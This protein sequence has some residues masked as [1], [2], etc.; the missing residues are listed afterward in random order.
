MLHK[1]AS[2]LFIMTFLVLGSSPLLADGDS[3]ESIVAPARCP[4]GCELKSTTF[5]DGSVDEFCLNSQ[6]GEKEGLYQRFSNDQK[7]KEGTYHNGKLEGLWSDY[8]QN[9]QIKST[10]EMLD[11][12]RQGIWHFYDDTGKMLSSENYVNGQLEG[13]LTHY[14]KN[15]QIKDKVVYVEGRKAGTF[16]SW[17]KNGKMQSSGEILHDEKQGKWEHWQEDGSSSGYY[18]Y[19]NNQLNG[20]SY[21]FWPDGKEKLK[22]NYLNG[23]YDGEFIEWFANGQ[24]KAEGNYTKGKKTGKWSYW[25]EDGKLQNSRAMQKEIYPLV[26]KKKYKQANFLI[27]QC[28]EKFP[29]DRKCLSFKKKISKK[30]KKTTTHHI[31]DAGVYE[32]GDGYQTWFTLVNK[33]GKAVKGVGQ[34]TFYLELEKDKDL[35]ESHKLETVEVKA[36]E[37]E[38][39]LVGEYGKQRKLLSFK[40]FIRFEKEFQ[41]YRKLKYNEELYLRFEFV[42][43]LGQTHGERDEFHMD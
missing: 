21:L 29:S 1:N 6:T 22:A 33:R 8:Y 20:L 43:Y 23:N 30:L 3:E 37:F 12:L 11:S 25:N 17:Y 41:R 18:H 28:L 38:L 19:K 32:E 40:H 5:K 27:L 24:K 39:Q 14:Y 31:K 15:G 10:G 7:L 2:L 4:E 13:M 42:D 26:K 36:E 16:N 9:G 34:V 35:V